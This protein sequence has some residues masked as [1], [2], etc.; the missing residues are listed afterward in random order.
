MQ[1]AVIIAVKILYEMMPE[2]SFEF[3][4]E[5]IKWLIQV[6]YGMGTAFQRVGSR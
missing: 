6:E 4:F 1:C 2:K 3:R 5:Q